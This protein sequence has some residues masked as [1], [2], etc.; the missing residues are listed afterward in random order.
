MTTSVA[1][2]LS[3]SFAARSRSAQTGGR[4]KRSPAINNRSISFSLHASITAANESQI[5]SARFFP[6]RNSASGLL[7]RCK[8]AM[9]IKRIWSPLLFLALCNPQVLRRHL[10]EVFVGVTF[11]QAPVTVFIIILC[12]ESPA[13]TFRLVNHIHLGCLANFHK[14]ISFA[15]HKMNINNSIRC[16]N[17]LQFLGM[18][19]RR[20]CC[21]FLSG[22]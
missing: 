3:N 11:P 5:S 13:T 9:C 4:S 19:L 22:T 7:P 10:G 16:H 12:F 6:Q 2:N 20:G 21:P 14:T 17:Y 15:D 8:S 1:V 18:E